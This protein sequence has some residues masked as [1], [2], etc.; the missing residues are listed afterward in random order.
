MSLRVSDIAGGLR[1]TLDR[2]DQANA[3]DDALVDALHAALRGAA[4]TGARLVVLDGNG[5]NFCGGFDFSG[6]EDCSDGDLLLRFVRIEQ[7]LQCLWNAPFVSV[8]L[9]HGAAFGAGADLVAASTYRI[10][11]PGCRFRFPGYRF[12][13]ALGTRRLGCV[14]GEQ[15]ARE[16]LLANA[17]LDSETARAG[18]LLT[19]VADR[20]AWDAVVAGI[21]DGL[22]GLDRTA[23]AALL[24]NVRADPDADARDL[25]ALVRSAAEPGL[26]GR[27]AAYRAAAAGQRRA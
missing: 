2:P 27:I 25:A 12:G 24:R 13:I 20:D 5:R 1:L 19:Q 16:I 8:A 14:V 15:R 11:A 23:T 9:V 18:G 17:V 7:V 21:G 3:V 22:A 4:E 6:I 10:G 26:R